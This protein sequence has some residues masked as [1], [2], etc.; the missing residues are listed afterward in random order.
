MGIV[1]L[2][3][4]LILQSRIAG[5]HDKNMSSFVRKCQTPSK[6]TLPFWTLTSIFQTLKN[7]FGERLHFYNEVQTFA[8]LYFVCIQKLGLFE[9]LKD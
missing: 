7:S 5:W 8:S 3:F 1:F 2:L 6:V 4:A 9:F